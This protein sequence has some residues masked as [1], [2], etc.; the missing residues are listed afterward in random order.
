MNDLSITGEQLFSILGNRLSSYSNLSG[1]ALSRGITLYQGSDYEGAVREFRRAISLDPYSDNTPK[2]YDF[3][4][5]AYLRLG[6]TEDA[7]KTFKE[8]IRLFPNIDSIHLK[9]GN[10]YYSKEDYDGAEA[11]YIKAVSLNPST[12]NLYSLGQLYLSTDR[13][14]K[15]EE[16]FLR[17]LR[18]E[19]NNYGAL[20]SLGQVYARQGK[21]NEAIKRFE[22]AI[23]I[24]RDFA[25]AY[26]D[27][28]ALYAD[29]GDPEMAERQAVILDSLNQGLAEDLRAYIYKVRMP[30][31][32][33]VNTFN[34]FN[35]QKG[36][37]TPV[38][39]LDSA[40]T[41]PG[42]SKDFSIKV[43]FDKM[44]D[45]ASIENISNWSITRAIGSNP[46][47]LYN[48]GLPVPDTEVTLNPLPK[49]VIYNSDE[50]TATVIFTVRQNS[51]GDGT[52]D[53]SHLVFKFSGKDA[54]G[55]KMNPEADEFVGLSIIV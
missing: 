55:N 20:Y 30:E 34:A 43:Y 37:G 1:A 10:L 54:Y 48:W 31:I 9:L 19:P 52:I 51:T 38:S 17:I 6:R 2:A 8:A 36:P 50:F 45:R 14:S 53:P 15:A 11:E 16:I 29:M 35:M 40:L 44:M 7:E 27:L 46:G 13:Y 23:G 22:E 32:T 3:M 47:G 33:F 12:E 24:K 25:Y 5:Q 26:Y 41:E 21:P 42:S 18:T 39:S 49:Q 28:G 4:A